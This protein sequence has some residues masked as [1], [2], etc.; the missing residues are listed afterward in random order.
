MEWGLVLLW[1]NKNNFLISTHWSLFIQMC[2]IA[3][4]RGETAQLLEMWVAYFTYMLLCSFATPR[5][6]FHRRERPLYILEGARNMYYK[7]KWLGSW[8]DLYGS[9]HIHKVQGYHETEQRSANSHPHSVWQSSA[10]GAIYRRLHAPFS[11]NAMQQHLAF[12]QTRPCSSECFLQNGDPYIR[13]GRDE[14]AH[15]LA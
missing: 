6:F 5:G 11:I 14:P 10:S 1:K 2:A 9:I 4:L 15:P 3:K 8:P 7:K 13:G 12:F